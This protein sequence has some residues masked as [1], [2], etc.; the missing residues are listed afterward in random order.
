MSLFLDHYII[1]SS[2]F[3]FSVSDIKILS[4]MFRKRM[5]ATLKTMEDQQIAKRDEV[6]FL[7]HHISFWSMLMFKSVMD[8]K[9][10][11]TH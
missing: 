4:C 11:L 5:D 10:K 3:A 6:L 7:K 8:V 2:L 1:N 9:L